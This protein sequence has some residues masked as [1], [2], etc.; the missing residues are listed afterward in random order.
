MWVDFVLTKDA[1]D[2]RRFARNIP[3]LK[4]L[5]IKLMVSLVE[6]AFVQTEVK[7]GVRSQNEAMKKISL[8]NEEVNGVCQHYRTLYYQS[9]LLN[10]VTL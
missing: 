4:A 7:L 6:W 5:P 8:F 10:I 9:L 2:A 1:T 3:L